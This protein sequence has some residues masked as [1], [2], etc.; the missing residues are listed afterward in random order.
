MWNMRDAAQTEQ[1][2][3][4]PRPFGG[5]SRPFARLAPWLRA[6]ER[7]RPEIGHALSRAHAFERARSPGIALAGA[8]A[9]G[10][11]APPRLSADGV[12]TGA[13][14]RAGALRSGGHGG[15]PLGSRG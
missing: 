13:R 9:S 2:A 11:A 6:L 15:R 10:A 1:L 3:P 7:D 12:G 8:R 5:L 14:P 4:D